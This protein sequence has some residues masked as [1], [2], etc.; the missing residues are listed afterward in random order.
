MNSDVNGPTI[1]AVRLH[2]VNPN[3]DPTV[4]DRM[5]E[6]LSA[7][8]ELFSQIVDKTVYEDPAKNTSLGDLMY[9]I[10]GERDTLTDNVET[11]R[12]EVGKEKKRQKE[13]AK[14]TLYKKR[15]K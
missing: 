12:K 10:T 11:D 3:G 13:H 1:K 4:D 15:G 6:I 2:A 5:K 8:Y 14:S 9:M 7:K